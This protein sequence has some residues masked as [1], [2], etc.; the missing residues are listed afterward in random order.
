MPAGK[1]N[2]AQA[3]LKAIGDLI[4]ADLMFFDRPSVLGFLLAAVFVVAFSNYIWSFPL[5][6]KDA[7]SILNIWSESVSFIQT[8]TQHLV[9][10]FQTN[11]GR[12]DG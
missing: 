9:E 11:N 4:Y 8:R 6:R 10:G 2:V 3:E 12:E 7:Q 5:R 1:F